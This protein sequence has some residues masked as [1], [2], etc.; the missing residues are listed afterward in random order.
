LPK[1]TNLAGVDLLL[2]QKK[3]R[4]ARSALEPILAEHPNDPDVHLRLAR[5][6]AIEDD[7]R[8]A[9]EHLELVLG[10]L[11]GSEEARFLL[12]AIELDEKNFGEAEST[13]LDLLR[14][15]PRNARYL[16]FYGRV[17]LLSLHIE[18]ARRLAEEAIRISPESSEA[19]ILNA[20]VGVVQGD[21][22]LK[23]DA[24]QELLRS[25]PDGEQVLAVLFYALVQDNRDREAL[26]VGAE[27]LRLDPSDEKFIEA[28]IALKVSTHWS[29]VPLYPMIRWGWGGS[30]LVWGFSIV[31]LPLVTKQSSLLGAAAGAFYLAY[32]L[33]S[34]IYPSLLRRWFRRRGF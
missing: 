26:R 6:A 5:A 33:Y 23:E 15:N 29:M 25:E 30:A 8:S 27:L 20:L 3:T 19:L 4:A 14:N 9:R 11:P 10:E 31:L 2:S 21:R 34:W 32:I 1:A 24:L 7:N 28:L 16:A 12:A 18:K 22:N 13:I 17:M